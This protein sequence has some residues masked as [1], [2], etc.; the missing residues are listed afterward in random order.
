M[1]NF[2]NKHKLTILNW[3]YIIG[4]IVAIEFGFAF[5]YMIITTGL[6]I[7]IYHKPLWKLIKFGADYYEDFC[8]KKGKD[9]VKGLK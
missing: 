4:L 7:V 6:I 5:W 9:L 1:L 2:I 8:R 3:S